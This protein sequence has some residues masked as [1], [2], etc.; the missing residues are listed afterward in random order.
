MKFSPKQV[1]TRFAVR[2]SSGSRARRRSL[3]AILPVAADCVLE[4]RLVLDGGSGMDNMPPALTVNLS[5]IPD[6]AVNGD[7]VGYAT[8]TD[9]DGDTITFS[10]EGGSST[11]PSG[12]FAIDGNTGVI[13]VA[14][15]DN[16]GSQ[17][18]NDDSPAGWSFTMTIVASD[19]PAS[20]GDSD[21]TVYL[22][23][24]KSPY[25]ILAPTPNQTFRGSTDDVVFQAQR[26][27]GVRVRAQLFRINADGTETLF[28]TKEFAGSGGTTVEH[29]F[30]KG[31]QGE[32]KI[33][34]SYRTGGNWEVDEDVF[35]TLTST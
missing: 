35:F 29:N 9:A 15:A 25:Q 1:F 34:F 20:P 26:A 7:V 11:D 27:K 2:I 33:S 22:D 30:G 4:S 31:V 8:A 19:G 28:R 6:S 13:T 21:A 12:T 32:Y 14:N 16:I 3:Q 23:V 10:F 18:E 17:D 5:P 24:M